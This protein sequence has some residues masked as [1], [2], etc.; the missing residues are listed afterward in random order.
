M[1]IC[2]SY[3]ILFISLSTFTLEN[4]LAYWE[5]ALVSLEA[6]DI[7]PAAYAVAKPAV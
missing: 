4:L 5:I 6:I 3:L 7:L 2:T 1:L